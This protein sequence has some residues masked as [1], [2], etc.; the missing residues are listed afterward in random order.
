[1]NTLKGERGVA[2]R[3]AGNLAMLGVES[4]RFLLIRAGFEPRWP[5]TWSSACGWRA[6]ASGFCGSKEQRS[7]M[8]RFWRVGAVKQYTQLGAGMKKAPES[9]FQVWMYDII[10]I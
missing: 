7:D 8:A 4:Q 10:L 5:I 9:A 1:M 6:S 3:T 2:A